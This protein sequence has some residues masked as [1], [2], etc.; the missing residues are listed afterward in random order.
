[1]PDQDAMRQHI[2]E[3]SEDYGWK[4]EKTIDTPQFDKWLEE[5][6]V[7]HTEDNI[8]FYATVVPDNIPDD[9]IDLDCFQQYLVKYYEEVTGWLYELQLGLPET[10]EDKDEVKVLEYYDNSGEDYI[11]FDEVQLG[12]ITHTCI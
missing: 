10:F 5:Q 7:E 9:E 6:M 3:N 2:T 11:E 8:R 1:M 12:V 4:D